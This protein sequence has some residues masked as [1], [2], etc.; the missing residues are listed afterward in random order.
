MAT[1]ELGVEG[2]SLFGQPE[3]GSGAR[4]PFLCF[5]RRSAGDVVY[6]EAKVAGSAQRRR[7][8]AVLQHGSVLLGRSPAAPEL[9]G[10]REVCGCEL[11]CGALIDTWLPRLEEHLGLAFCDCTLGSEHKQRAERYAEVKYASDAWTKD[12]DAR[13]SRE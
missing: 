11:S 13:L 6:G 2:A 7:H 3:A 9:P 8:D 5:E 1:W 4:R 12:R 10:I